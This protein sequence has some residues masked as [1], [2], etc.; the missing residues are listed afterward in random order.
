VGVDDGELCGPAPAVAAPRSRDFKHAGEIV[1]SQRILVRHD[2]GGGALRHDLAAVNAC[3]RAEIDDMIG[4]KNCV[5]VMFD[6][7]NRIA[8]IAQPPQGVEKPCIV[9]LMQ[10]TRRFV[11]HVAHAGQ[12]R[13][14]LRGEPDALA[15]AAGQRRKR[16]RVR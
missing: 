3:A 9:A 7:N 12:A 4:G 8:E 2:L 10:Y 13:P 15:L 1:A 14:N 6:N 5:L 11:E 16:E